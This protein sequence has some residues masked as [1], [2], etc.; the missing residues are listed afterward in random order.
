MDLM[1]IIWPVG[2]MAVMG[3]VFGASLAFASQ[4]FAVETDSRVDE[5]G[6]ILPQ[7][8]CG[9]CGYPGCA[10]YAEAVVGG[11]S[12]S[13]CSVGGP[14]VTARIAKIMGVESVDAA[15]RMVAKVK[16]MGGTNCVDDSVYQ[17]VSGCLAKSLVGGGPKSCKEGCLGDGDCI[18]ACEFNAMFLNEFGVVQVNPDNCVGCKLC[19]AACP[20]KIIEMVPEK[21]RVHVLCSNHEIGG[22]VRKNC[23]VACI[24]CRLCE[25]ACKFDA[26]HVIDN[27]AVIDYD[28]CTNCMACVKVCPTKAIEGILPKKKV[29]PVEEAV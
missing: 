27:V 18:E 29:L 12:V 7:A 15:G 23:S 11:E 16:C 8:N 20:K 25:K 28:K 6:A 24:A 17:G 13:L 14:P 21:A 10:S 1:N 19:V 22:H 3:T 5:I 9:A 26:I 4:R 2:S